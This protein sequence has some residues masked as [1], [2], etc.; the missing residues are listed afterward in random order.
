MP[1]PAEGARASV[2]IIF[3]PRSNAYFLREQN[4]ELARS[5][6]AAMQVIQQMMNALKCIVLMV[7]PSYSVIL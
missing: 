7:P 6:F 4:H 1:S 2:L 3:Q 5:G